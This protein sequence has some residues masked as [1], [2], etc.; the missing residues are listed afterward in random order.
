MAKYLRPEDVQSLE[1]FLQDVLSHME[2][3]G[4]AQHPSYDLIYQSYNHFDDDSNTAATLAELVNAVSGFNPAWGQ[5]INAVVATGIRQMN[6][7][8]SWNIA[9]TTPRDAY[10]L[11]HPGTGPGT[12]SC[13]RPQGSG[14]PAH[15]AS[16]LD[17]TIEHIYPVV[18]HWNTIGHD[19]TKIARA[20]WY[21]DLT[22]HEYLCQ[23]CNSSKGGGG[24]VYNIVTGTNYSN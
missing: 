17:C 22:N 10:K 15:D 23:A 9:E 13:P 1:I 14:L 8:S 20:N 7:P 21:R 18:S 6:Y 4:H 2:E 5:H 12:W 11:A 24:A 19:T 16:N 3:A